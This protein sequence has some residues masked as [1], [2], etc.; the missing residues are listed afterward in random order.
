LTVLLQTATRS[1]RMSRFPGVKSGG[2]GVD[3]WPGRFPLPALAQSETSQERGDS[4]ASIR[5]P[6][7][8]RGGRLFRLPFYVRWVMFRL[9]YPRV[10]CSFFFICRGCSFRVGPRATVRIGPGVYF[11]PGSQ[12]CLMGEADIGEGVY[13]NSH[14]HVVSYEK[15][16]IGDYSMFGEMASVHDDNHVVTP[17]EGARDLLRCRPVHVGRRVWVGAKATVLQGVTIGDGAVIGANAVVTRDVT[18][19]SV[20]GGIPASLIGRSAKVTGPADDEL[21]R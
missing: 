19:H 5:Q 8:H 2:L 11:S 3:K 7:R 10:R 16:T 13:F 20:V 9:R 17:G 4:T 6:W 1:S 14:C 21:G 15:I 18:A 12:V